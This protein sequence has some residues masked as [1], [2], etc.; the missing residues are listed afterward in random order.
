MSHP[1][2]SCVALFV[3]IVTCSA[4]VPAGAGPLSIRLKSDAKSDAFEVV[5]LTPAMLA[6]LRT[7]G[8]FPE[9]CAKVF[10]V[11]VET[12]SST[13]R[14]N[15]PPLLGTYELRKDA[16][17]FKPRFPLR[18][19]LH[20]R[21][22]F[23]AS[24]LRNQAGAGQDDVSRVFEIP[25]HR[26]TVPTL[27]QAVYPSANRL[28]ENQ[29]KFYIHFS[30]PMSRGDAYR[31]VHLLD[32]SGKPIPFAFLELDEELWDRD[33]KRFTLFFDP[34]R[35]KRGLKPREEFGPALEDGKSYA[36]VIDQA[37]PDADGQPMKEAYCKEFRV[38]PPDDQPPDPKT[39]KMELPSASGRK[40]V[41]VTFP[42]PMDH[43]L[44]GRM[45]RVTD[46]TGSKLEGSTAIGN[47]E[48][49]WSFQPQHPW[50]DGH[51][52]LIV[53]TALEDLAGNSIGHPFEID[54]FHPVQSHAKA[55]TLAIPI[56]I[57]KRP[58]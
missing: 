40:P 17:V 34:G 39:W 4:V 41:V 53:D 54:V 26:A 50:S 31:H 23:V 22:R 37:W 10:T 58:R 56:E 48:Q 15:Q 11:H 6:S 12:T 36:L 42:K 57:R 44:L 45:L 28:P 7:T 1:C 16:L 43:A 29:L 49:Q 9:A 32:A 33:H 19:G 38:G 52:E 51:Y 24:A 46:S 2:K 55:K 47:E 3:A 27:V 8:K 20:Y 21:A 30:A 35:I 13:D 18:P 25:T 14:R 5:G